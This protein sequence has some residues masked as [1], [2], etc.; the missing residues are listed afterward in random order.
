M[1]QDLLRKINKLFEKAGGTEPPKYDPKS[2]TEDLA[3]DKYWNAILYLRHVLKLASDDFFSVQQNGINVDLF[4]LTPSVSSPM[5]PGS[6]SEAVAIQFGNLDTFLVDSSQFGF[7]PILM[8]NFN[9]L[10]C[11]LPSMRGEKPDKRH[12]N[13]F[14]H[15]EAEMRGNLTDIMQLVEKYINRLNHLIN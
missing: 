6:D 4:M 14:F 8:N 13:Q 15:C 7:E 2:H 3:T 1:N 5:G 11:Y 9:L 10:Y 12:L